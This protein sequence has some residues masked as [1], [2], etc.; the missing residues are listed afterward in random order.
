MKTTL[1]QPALAMI[2]LTTIGCCTA[3]ADVFYTTQAA[4]NAAVSGPTTINFEGIVPVNGYAAYPGNTTVGGVQ[5]GIGPA[6][7][8]GLLFIIGDN[9]YGLGFATISSQDPGT[10]INPTNDL[11]VTLP[12]PVTALA[13]DFI[14]DPGT[15]TVA[16]SDGATQSLVAANTP[17]FGFFGVTA[18]GGISSVDI[19]EPYSLAAQSI[20]LSDFSYG[21][22]LPSAPTPEP[23]SLLLLATVVVA[24]VRGIAR[25]SRQETEVSAP[26]R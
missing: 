2:V 8:S 14:V 24:T 17:T 3:Q 19:T 15:V 9:F 6:S 12:S 10:G 16:L 5:F 23:F 22:A 1:L 26:T 7:P 18:P 21:T 13:F 4:W 25:R 11:L 20:N